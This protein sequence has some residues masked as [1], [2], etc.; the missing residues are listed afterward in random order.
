MIQDRRLYRPNVGIMVANPRG[1]VLWARRANTDIWQCPQGGID[2]GETPEQALAREL[3]EETGLALGRLRVLASTPGWTDYVIPEPL[4][5]RG[6]HVGQSQKWFLLRFD[7][8]DAEVD[9]SAGGAEPEFDAWRW[10]DPA[11]IPAQVAEFK[12][13]SYDRALREFRPHLRRP[14]APG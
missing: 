14:A 11:D 6:G 13:E 4:R 8:D 12:R 10:E 9:L 3:L 2:P 7:G 5:G 1:L